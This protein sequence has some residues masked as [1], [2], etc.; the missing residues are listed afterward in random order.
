VQ[1]RCAAALGRIRWN[2]SVADIFLGCYLTEPKP[3][4]YF[5]PPS[6]PLPSRAFAAAAARRGLSLDA[7]TQ[8]LY[9]GRCFFINGAA[10]ARPRTGGAAIEHLA[11]ARG[12]AAGQPATAAADKL[13]YRWYCDGYLHLD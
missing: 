11:D 7:R 4:V 9:D 10:I 2:R 8:L 13:L 1:T 6:R 12:M 5:T 3:N